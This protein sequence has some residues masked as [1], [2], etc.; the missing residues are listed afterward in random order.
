MSNIDAFLAMIGWSEGTTTVA[1]SDDGYNVLVGGTLFRSYADHP[2]ISV[3]LGNGLISTAAGRYQIREAIFDAYKRDLQLPDFS[4][5]S[6]DSIALQLIKECNAL[7]DISSGD[8][9]S[10][11]IKCA[12]RW[13]SLPGSQYGQHV[14]SMT[15]LLAQF[16]SAL[17]KMS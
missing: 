12:S 15:D 11:V 14:N 16:Q 6:Q 7:S 2:R 10:A 13:A 5:A 9:Q 8:I 3:N 4:P 1:G 17:T